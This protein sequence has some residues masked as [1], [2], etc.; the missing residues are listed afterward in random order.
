MPSGHS[1]LSP[2]ANNV[3][4]PSPPYVVPPLGGSPKVVTAP[5]SPHNKQRT[6]RQ[7]QAGAGGSIEDQCAAVEAGGAWQ[8]GGI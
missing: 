2:L 7:A 4:G 6:D 1:F 5:R 8:T 3:Q